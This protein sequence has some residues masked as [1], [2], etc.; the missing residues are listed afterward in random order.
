[1]KESLKRKNPLIGFSY[2][3]NVEDG[4]TKY[5]RTSIN[6]FVPQG[7][8]LGYQLALTEGDFDV[9]CNDDTLVRW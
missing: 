3:A 6:T 2:M 9:Y 1:M 5:V 7:C 4:N 8:V